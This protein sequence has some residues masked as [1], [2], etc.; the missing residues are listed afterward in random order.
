MAYGLL[1]ALHDHGLTVP[2]AVRTAG[3]VDLL[4]AAH[5]SP[6]LTTVRRDFTEL[7]QQMMGAISSILGDSWPPTR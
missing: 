2:S 4:E 5:F 1:S 7:E 6:P 3:S